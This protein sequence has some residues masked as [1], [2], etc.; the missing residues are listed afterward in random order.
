[1]PS[2][3]RALALAAAVL[4]GF[5]APVA[6]D[7]LLIDRVAREGAVTEPTRGMDMD[8]VLARYG[9]PATR[10]DPV[11]GDKPQHPPITKW[12]YPQFTVYFE[13]DKVID[14]VLNRST[15]LEQGP[16]PPQQ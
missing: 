15:A 9:E 1:M 3:A 4:A 14:V 7:T 8:D 13:H 10:F 11:G 16:K 12:A 6:A 5:A 2:A